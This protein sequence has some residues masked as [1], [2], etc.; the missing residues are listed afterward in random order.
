M[1]EIYREIYGQGRPLVMIHGWGMHTGI[2]REFA[3]QLAKHRQVICVDLPGHG[4]STAISDF[5]LETLGSVLINAIPVEKFSLL[6]WSLGASIAMHLAGRYPE[7]IMEL[8]LLAGNPKFI[9]D[10]CWP[11]VKAE[12]LDR[13]IEQL[14]TEPAQTLT[15]FLALQVNGLSDSRQLLQQLKSAVFEVEIPQYETLEMG[16]KILK[17]ADL[18]LEL[19]A[20][21]CP[22]T[23]IQGDKDSLVPL[24]SGFASQKLNPYV[25]VQ[26][27]R[28]A[29]HLPFLSHQLELLDIVRSVA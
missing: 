20:L 19:S 24:A 11:G 6:G 13:F 29:G 9:A 26:I 8:L 21:Q 4:R 15:R 10:E 17:Y 25:N 27:I 28:N 18:R 7:K 5:N 16:L 3:Q 22:V 1:S 23:F 12:F 14:A 2:W